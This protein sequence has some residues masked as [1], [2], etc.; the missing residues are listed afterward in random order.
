TKPTASTTPPGRQPAASE[1]VPPR[2]IRAE[3]DTT[4]PTS[5]DTDDESRCVRYHAPHARTPGDSTAHRRQRA[6]LT[7]SS[8]TTA[9]STI[10]PSPLV[11]RATATHAAA[12]ASWR[13]SSRSRCHHSATS[14][15]IGSEKFIRNGKSTSVLPAEFHTTA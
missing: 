15:A 11:A 8:T 10:T 2:N 5:R 4:A 14:A 1:V 12:A 9:T 13:S 6:R 3:Y 7:A